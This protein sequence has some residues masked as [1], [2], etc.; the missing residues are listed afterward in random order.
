[1]VCCWPQGQFFACGSAEETFLSFRFAA[2]PQTGTIILA[3]DRNHNF[4]RAGS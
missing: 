2:M 4:F 1:V 3:A